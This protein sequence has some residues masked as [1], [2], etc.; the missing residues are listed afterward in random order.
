M[1]SSTARLTLH[2]NEKFKKTLNTSC[3][4][5]MNNGVDTF[6]EFVVVGYNEETGKATMLKNADALTLGLA[7]K[8]IMK[9]FKESVAKLSPETQEL[10]MVAIE[11]G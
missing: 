6:G 1:T 5:K 3:T 7:S 11:E 9:A 2:T 10:L 4:V 8:I